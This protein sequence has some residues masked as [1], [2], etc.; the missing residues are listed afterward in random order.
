[1]T[2]RGSLRDF[3]VASVDE[4]DSV[5]EGNPDLNYKDLTLPFAIVSSELGP[6]E[7]AVLGDDKRIRNERVLVEICANDDEELT[8]L[9]ESVR[10][11][12]DGALAVDE[13][14]NTMKGINLLMRMWKMKSTDF[15]TYDGGQ[16]DLFKAVAPQV[17][18]N[19]NLMNVIRNW[20]TDQAFGV[21]SEK[22]FFIVQNNRLNP[23]PTVTTGYRYESD[24][25]QANGATVGTFD[26]TDN[27]VGSDAVVYYIKTSSDGANWN[28]Q[29]N[30][31]KGAVLTDYI[32]DAPFW[33]WG[34]EA[35]L[36]SSQSYIAVV[37]VQTIPGLS[38]I[39]YSLGTI[40]FPSAN[41]FNDDIR[42][43]AKAGIVD[44]NEVDVHPVA[45]SPDMEGKFKFS[46]LM[47][48]ETNLLLKRTSEVV[49]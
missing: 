31:P 6:D 38:T 39:N 15:I 30:I 12:V 27:M 49:Y 28:G 47:E 22:D 34:C 48:Y 5:S 42:I 17:W 32:Q 45:V 13:D 43:T 9:I 8:R 26:V 2:T 14:G 21:F 29:V 1:M 11:A 40:R 41:I 3:I 36:S 24:T 4:F 19:F 7:S 10:V 33:R 20:K 35:T 18:K 37:Q 25:I 44:L 16:S 46:A 23:D